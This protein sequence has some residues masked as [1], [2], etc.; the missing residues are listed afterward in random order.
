[1]RKSVKAVIDQ[2]NLEPG[3]PN[4]DGYPQDNLMS[5]WNVTRHGWDLARFLFPSRP[6]RYVT[7]TYDLGHYAANKATAMSCRE[8]GDIPAALVYESICQTIYNRL[9]GY[10][11][12]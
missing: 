3:V 5:F 10:A 1:M 8:K 4:L 9:P 7:A 11:R 12:W 6:E 2:M